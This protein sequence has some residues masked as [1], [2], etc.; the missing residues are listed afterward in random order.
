MPN[1]GTSS[2]R[3][4]A[5]TEQ[6]GLRFEPH[7]AAMS[8]LAGVRPAASGVAVDDGELVARFGPWTVRTPLGNID[9]VSRTGPYQWFK[10]IGSPHISLRDRGLTFAGTAQ[11]GVC[12][13]FRE[14]VRGIDPLG[15]VRHPAL[16]VTVEDPDTFVTALRER[17]DD[18][19]YED[20]EE[21]IPEIEE[22][23]HD[24]LESLT[25]AELRTIARAEG[26]QRTSRLKKDELIKAIEGSGDESPS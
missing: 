4:D 10:V 14:P 12:V 17:L 2:R 13:H 21:A 16:T 22:E 7:F 15:I 26:V 3:N 9:S 18:D 19:V 20:V 5:D 6:F 23:E 11:A 25:A 1:T 8:M 24:E